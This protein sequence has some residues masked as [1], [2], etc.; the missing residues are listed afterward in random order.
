MRVLTT[1]K[2]LEA[3][4]RDVADGPFVTVDTEFI[5]DSTYWPKLCLL[6]F[7][8]A[9]DAY[10]ADPLAPKLSLK[11]FYEVLT[12]PKVIKV[13]HAG[14]Q[15][16]EIF[17][18]DAGV[19]PTPLFDT[20]VAA[21]ACGFGD[22][23]S[24][25]SLV[26]R[27]ARVDLDKSQRFTDWARRPLSKAQLNYAAGD[28]IHLHAVYGALSKELKRK[29]RE[30]WLREEMDILTRPS[31]YE[32]KPEDAWKRL[33]IKGNARRH[34]GVLMEVAAWREHEAQR[35]NVPR[36]RIL[37]DDAIH[38]IVAQR[39]STPADFKKLRL[40]S[41]N[42]QGRID[43]LLEAVAKGQKRPNSELPELTRS[44]P[45]HER[46]GALIDL[47]KVLLKLQC[48]R[49]GVAQK[50]VANTADLEAIAAEDDAHVAA[51]KG[52]RYE[53]FGE[54]ALRLKRREIALTADDHGANIIE[55]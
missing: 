8:G 24:Y 19:I 39:P 36:N 52:W 32:L 31:T 50:L 10:V 26:K 28:V 14:R 49:H 38:E 37:K 5:R 16:V 15:D 41:R 55:L 12:N 44:R 9:N 22:S 6:Q 54:W 51:M 3:A 35:L 4:C 40:A 13:V 18:H 53:I 43:S 25:E 1:T 11:P 47:L 21:M 17:Y 23:V 30:S 46:N 48:E 29:K 34:L 7:A 20:Q 45:S 27:F 2:E 42:F 33:K